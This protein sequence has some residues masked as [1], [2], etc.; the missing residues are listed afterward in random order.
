MTTYRLQAKSIVSAF[1]WHTLA[2]HDSLEAMAAACDSLA[3]DPDNRGLSRADATP[4][5]YRVVDQ[6]LAVVCTPATHRRASCS[7]GRVVTLR[8]LGRPARGGRD[9]FVDDRAANARR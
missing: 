7:A 1:G 9:S 6:S 8:L 3:N 5:D 2:E 4:C